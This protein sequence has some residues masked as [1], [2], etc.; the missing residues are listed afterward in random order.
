VAK[1]DKPLNVLIITGAGASSH[2]G[3]DDTALPMMKG[4]AA[5]LIPRLGF[6]ADQLGLTAATDG[7]AFEAIIGRF[8]NFSNS[9]NAVAASTLGPLMGDQTNIVGNAGRN[10]S[11]GN[12]NAWLS[13]AQNNVAVLNLR[14]WES[15]WENFGRDRI[16]SEK[17]DSA[18]TALHAL[19]RESSGGDQPCYIAHAT[20]N[21]DTA[22]EVAIQESKGLELLDGF[23][24]A[25]GNARQRWAPNL[26]TASRLDSDARIP[27]VHLHGAVGWYYDPADRNLVQRRPSDD[28]LD[29]RM[30]PA[31]LLPDDTK[32]PDLF[33]A[34][35]AEVWEQFIILLREATHVFMI[36]HSLHDE[37]LVKAVN[38]AK[39]ATAVMSLGK[40]SVVTPAKESSPMPLGHPSRRPR[41][42]Q[43]DLLDPTEADRIK[44]KI[45]GASVIPG[46]FGEGALSSDFD[47]DAFTKFLDR[48]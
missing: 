7:P 20:T 4:W 42:V 45:R 35:L 47:A 37:H 23:A 12:F 29:D 22:I 30:T 18:Y 46:Q 41:P 48:N 39:V 26:L 6:A 1:R 27:V 19:I 5:D 8:L 16:D 24:P 15:L 36:G 28:R 44:R 14:V 38:E 33:P 31:L 21:F 17:A 43:W 25:S 11:G 13:T 10:A 2:L 3:V 9:L 32:R 40:A 34:P